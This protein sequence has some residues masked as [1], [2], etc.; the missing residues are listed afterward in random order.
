MDLDITSLKW[1]IVLF[2]VDF[3]G[4]PHWRHA[5]WTCS[6]SGVA[7]MA[8]DNDSDDQL[9]DFIHSYSYSDYDA[10]TRR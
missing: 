9:D 7:N 5:P 8:E 1:Y 6:Q 4:S 10:H 2:H 3:V